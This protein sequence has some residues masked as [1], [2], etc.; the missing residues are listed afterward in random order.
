VGALDR[1]VGDAGAIA[2]AAH[3]WQV[4]PY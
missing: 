3:I 2:L 1:P 4:L